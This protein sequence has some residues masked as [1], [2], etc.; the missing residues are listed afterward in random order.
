MREVGDKSRLMR[1]VK[2][3]HLSG[4]IG[5]AG[6]MC[7]AVRIETLAPNRFFCVPSLANFSPSRCLAPRGSLASPTPSVRG[8]QFA[9]FM[10]MCIDIV[11]MQRRIR[12]SN[13]VLCRAIYLASITTHDASRAC[14]L[15]A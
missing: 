11:K 14:G 5:F 15:I 9:S 3:T 10:P 12:A 8:L 2:M 1:F 4:A 6:D 13:D 7:V